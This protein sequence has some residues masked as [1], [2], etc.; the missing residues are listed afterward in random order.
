MDTIPVLG[1]V[2]YLQNFCGENKII[3]YLEVPV[4]NGRM[5]SK[6]VLKKCNRRTWTGLIWLRKGISVGLLLAR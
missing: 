6:C 4:L 5:V 1:N 2:K 3:Y